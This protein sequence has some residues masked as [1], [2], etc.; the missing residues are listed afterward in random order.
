MRFATGVDDDLRP[1]HDAF[2]DDPLIGAVGAR[3]PAAA[4][5]APPGA[6][7]GALLGGLRAADRVPARGRDRARDR[8]AGSAGAAPAAGCATCR[9]P[10][11]L[12]ARRPGASS[13][14][15]GSA[16]GRS[17]ALRRAAARGRVGPRRPARARPRAR[18]GAPAGD[19]RDRAVDG[20]RPRAARPGPLRPPARR[21]PGLPALRRAPAARPSA[22]RGRPRTRCA[23]CSRP[24]GRWAGLAGRAR[25]RRAGRPGLAARDGARQLPVGSAPTSP[26]PSPGRNSFVATVPTSTGRVS[27][28]LRRIQSA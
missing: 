16:P 13:S 17:L 20:R 19:P 12:A 4:R 23:S 7:R 14:A 22:R 18:L 11:T 27:R 10:A 26:S 21:R 8:R 5:P 24:Y 28:S 2:R 15:W 25:A 9:T 6:V 3:A 1:F